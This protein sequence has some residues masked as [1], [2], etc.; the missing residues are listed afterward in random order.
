VA[1]AAAQEKLDLAQVDDVVQRAIQVGSP[2]RLRVLG[3]GEITLVVGWPTDDPA[4]AVKRL[5]LLRS[6]SQFECYGELL[7]DYVGALRDRGVSVVPTEL[8]RAGQ[9]SDGVHAYLV[10]PLVP[11]ERMLNVVLRDCT[12]G[13]AR[14]LLAALVTM[15][16]DSVDDRVGLDAQAANWA[17]EG[18]RLATVDVST[19][20]LRDEQGR[21]RLDLELFLSVYP[22]AM[23]PALARV[24]HS[25][26][27]QYHDPRTVLIDVASNLI[28]E[29]H[30]RWLPA[31]LEAANTRVEP[32]I[33]QEEAR[34]YFK[35]DRRLWLL[36]QRLRHV[37]RTWQR[38]VR[39]RPYPFLLAPPYRYGPHPTI[40][41][42]R[43]S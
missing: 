14:E 10:Q 9:A 40:E 26:M 35:R 36:M 13:H 32:A 42:R 25:V 23:R 15:V 18:E 39:R 4:F 43:P 16:V 2:S 8:R 11:H 30:A 27:A 37:D 31:L 22:W 5:P 19:P 6:E 1:V 29:H 41:T 17:V 33:T 12:P 21:D 28:K 34:R 38:H 24:A 20:L 3:Y 7:H